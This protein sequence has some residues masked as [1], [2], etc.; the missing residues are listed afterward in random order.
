MEAALFIAFSLAFLATQV[1]ENWF[2]EKERFDNMPGAGV[3]WHTWQFIGWALTFGAVTLLVWEWWTAVRVLFVT[4]VMWWIIYDGWL[5]ALKNR[6]WFHQSKESSAEL[7]RLARAEIKIALLIAGAMLFLVGCSPSVR[8]IDRVTVDTIRV[9]PPVIVEQLPAKV[10]TDTVIISNKIIE[11][12]TVVD[13]RYYP[14]EKRFYVK[15]KPDTVT[16]L[17]TDTV[18]VTQI[19]PNEDAPTPLWVWVGLGLG[20]AF[21]IFIFVKRS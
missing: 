13:V 14:Q 6:A 8:Y 11:N 3:A 17:K 15:V 7:E 20:A 18:A 9:V 5:N 1:L 19:L 2:R 10:I 12:D 16:I 21:M 4:S